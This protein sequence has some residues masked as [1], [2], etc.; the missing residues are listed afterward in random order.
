MNVDDWNAAIEAAAIKIEARLVDESGP[1]WGIELT[2]QR[3]EIWR[4]NATFED[5]ARA[6]RSLKRDS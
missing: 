4:R 3:R 6:I 5:C 1:D 2:E